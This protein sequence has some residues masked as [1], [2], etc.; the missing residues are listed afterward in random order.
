MGSAIRFIDTNFIF[1]MKPEI[2]A[3]RSFKLYY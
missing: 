3:R 2:L 1:E